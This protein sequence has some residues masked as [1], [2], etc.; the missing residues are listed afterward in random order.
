[1]TPRF[2]T[3]WPMSVATRADRLIRWLACSLLGLPLLVG[4]GEPHAPPPDP[5]LMEFL[6]GDDV[7]PELAKY[8]GEQ[9]TVKR[10]TPAPPPPRGRAT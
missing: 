10:P 8:L 2:T 3:G 6:G 4:A 7:D 1:M 5:E 9:E